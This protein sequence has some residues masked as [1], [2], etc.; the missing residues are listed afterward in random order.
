MAYQ[1][2]SLWRSS[3]SMQKKILTIPE[4][5]HCIRKILT[6]KEKFPQHQ[7]NYRMI[8]KILTAKKNSRSFRKTLHGIKN[9]F[10]VS[11]KL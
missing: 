8:T 7:E 9:V 10:P 3:Y 6:A 11:E 2:M 4:K 1:K 5:T